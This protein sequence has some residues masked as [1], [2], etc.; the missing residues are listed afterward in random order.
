MSNTEIACILSICPE[1]GSGTYDGS[2][3]WCRVPQDMCRRQ[4][5]QGEG[6]VTMS[7][8]EISV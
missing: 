7:A 1:G 6:I 4:E 3:P 8:L 5:S 2:I